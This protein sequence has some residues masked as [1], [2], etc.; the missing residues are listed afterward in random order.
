MAFEAILGFTLK[1]EGGFGDDP[2]DPGGRT[3]FGIT[4]RTFDS[5]GKRDVWKITVAERD[6]IYKQRYWDV[7]PPVED[8]L[9]MAAFDSGVNVGVARAIPWI[10]GS[11]TWSDYLDKR[12]AYY[13]SRGT[14]ADRYRKGWRNRVQALRTF[15]T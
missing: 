11:A 8:K 2:H 9:R 1:W 3:A 5:S 4:Q 6:A 13:D 14:W 12:Q 10:E 7:L 15:L